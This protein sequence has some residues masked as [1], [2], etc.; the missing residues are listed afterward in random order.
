MVNVLIPVQLIKEIRVPVF[1]DRCE[2]E[3]AIRFILREFFLARFDS[4][5]AEKLSLEHGRR[6]VLEIECN[7]IPN[8]IAYILLLSDDLVA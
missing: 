7:L 6:G 8:V 3:W 1:V 5:D 2:A 4:G